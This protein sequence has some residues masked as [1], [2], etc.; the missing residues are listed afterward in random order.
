MKVENIIG[1]SP[2]SDILSVH[3]AEKPDPPLV[4]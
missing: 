1:L 4:P 3:Y 2:Y